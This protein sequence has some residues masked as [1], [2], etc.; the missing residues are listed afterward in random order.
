M[1]DVKRVKIVISF[2]TPTRRNLNIDEI[3]I[4]KIAGFF[5]V[6]INFH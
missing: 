6:K 1:P 4:V 5:K 3:N 2:T